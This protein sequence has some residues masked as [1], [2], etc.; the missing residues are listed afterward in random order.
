M[1]L[2]GFDEMMRFQLPRL[3]LLMNRHLKETHCSFI[4]TFFENLKPERYKCGKYGS[5]QERPKNALTHFKDVSV[6]KFKI[7]SIPLVI[8]PVL[9]GS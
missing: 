6:L 5:N 4:F 1:R 9:F 8:H 3:I 7:C 2:S